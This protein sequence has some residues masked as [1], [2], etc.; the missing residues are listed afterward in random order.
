M[1]ETWE[2]KLIHLERLLVQVLGAFDQAGIDVVLLKGAAAAV[3][4]YDGFGQRPMI[5]IDLLVAEKDAEEA[6][7]ISRRLG[8]H[9]DSQSYPKEMYG[10][11]H[12]LPPLT[13]AFGSGCG[14]EIHTRLW[15][16]GH[17]FSFGEDDV[18]ARAVTAQVDGHAC[19]VPHINH[20]LLHCCIHFAWSHQLQSRA[21][22][23]FSDIDAFVAS[24]R[25][26]WDDFVLLARTSGADS[27]CY[28]TLRLAASVTDVTVPPAVL[29]ALRPSGPEVMLDALERH[30][31]INL[32]PDG[33]GSPSVALSRRLWQM[34]VQ[35]GAGSKGI[36]LPAT[37]DP[38]GVPERIAYHSRRLPEWYRYLRKLL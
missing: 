31:L 6:W 28:W 2:F 9:W 16:P 37:P 1:A 38:K 23:A 5:D 13:D 22:R 21:W 15:L 3:T 25:V 20:Q 18:R 34:G 36:D 10:D 27:C 26:D 30:Y 32:L 8:W 11:A 19:R 24:G 35:R 33:D 4:V 14:L 29:E 7:T 12:H 17:P